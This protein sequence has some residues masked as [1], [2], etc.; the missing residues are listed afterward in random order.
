MGQNAVMLSVAIFGLLH[1]ANPSPGWTVAA[2]NSMC[3]RKH[4]LGAV[5]SSNIIDG[6]HFLSSIEVVLL[7]SLSHC[8]FN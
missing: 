3:N 5:V 6:A 2:V 4:I 8:L 1:G 7:I